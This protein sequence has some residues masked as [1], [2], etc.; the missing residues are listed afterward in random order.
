VK[1]EQNQKVKS[2]LDAIRKQLSTHPSKENQLGCDG[3]HE[4]LRE[5]LA[6]SRALTRLRLLQVCLHQA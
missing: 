4:R 5:L 1:K 6:N 3:F 2:N